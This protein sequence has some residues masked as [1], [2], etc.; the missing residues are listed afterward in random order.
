MKIKKNK[1]IEKKIKTRT[2]AI[3]K[4]LFKIINKILNNKTYK[5]FNRYLILIIIIKINLML[6]NH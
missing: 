5:D 4:I 1:T 2:K 6:V 3:I